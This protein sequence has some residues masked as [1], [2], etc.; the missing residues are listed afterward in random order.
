MSGFAVEL[1]LVRALALAPVLARNAF[2]TIQCIHRM[3]FDEVM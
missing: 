3:Q 1:P 2:K